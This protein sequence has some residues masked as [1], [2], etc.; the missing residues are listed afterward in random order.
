MWKRVK[1]KKREFRVASTDYFC[2]LFRKVASYV[3]SCSLPSCSHHCWLLKI[4]GCEKSIYPFPQGY[5]ERKKNG[6]PQ[7]MAWFLL[8]FFFGI[9]SFIPFPCASEGSRWGFAYTEY[10][11]VKVPTAWS[12][13]RGCTRK[14]TNEQGMGGAGIDTGT[15]KD[16]LPYFTQYIQWEYQDT[17]QRREN[18][19]NLS[20]A[21]CQIKPRSRFCCFIPPLVCVQV[22][23]YTSTC[24][25]GN[26][27]SSSPDWVW[28]P[29]KAGSRIGYRT[30][31]G[32]KNA[33]LLGESVSFCPPSQ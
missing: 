9:H 23:K 24:I 25:F 32:S 13:G 27:S 20:L 17:V 28:R 26:R 10:N 30:E 18:P 29:G 19:W 2:F 16:S 14:W 7:K 33:W 6:S 11:A 22:Y 12:L 4:V 21:V 5:F 1:K 31:A 15:R 8:S 3:M